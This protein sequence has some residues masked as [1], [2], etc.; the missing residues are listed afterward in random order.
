MKP[1]LPV[2]TIVSYLGLKAVVVEDGPTGFLVLCEGGGDYEYWSWELDG[3]AC[4]IVACPSGSD[5]WIP[6]NGK[7]PELSDN[8]RVD[9]K[10][11]DGAIEIGRWADLW[12]WAQNGT[13]HDITHYRIHLP[14]EQRP[15]PCQEC[16][17][18]GA[19]GAHEEDCSMAQHVESETP[20]SY[21]VSGQIFFRESS[22]EWVL[23]LTGSINGTRFTARHTQP[24]DTRPE[25]VA[26]LPALYEPTPDVTGLVEALENIRDYWNRDPNE[27]AMSDALWHIIAVADATLATHCKNGGEK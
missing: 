8:T 4:E 9:I 11:A 15:L 7:E 18:D 14:A 5:R 16:G 2:G 21:P 17:G 27:Y 6:S 13:P 19:G 22:N 26:G 24:A 1:V 3:H 23:E 25:D 12:T 20:E 10:F